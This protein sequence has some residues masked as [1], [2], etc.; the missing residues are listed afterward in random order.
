MSDAS[1]EQPANDTPP[2]PP[3][4][5]T[6]PQPHY[7]AQGGATQHPAAGQHPSGGQYPHAGQYP[8][9]GQYGAGG[10]QH[11]PGAYPQA[12]YGQG[13]YAYP[14]GPQGQYPQQ[15]AQPTYPSARPAD[16]RSAQGAAFG[17]A[18][19]DTQPTL[20]I[21]SEATE[22]DEPKK[23]SGAGKVI[24]LL[25]AAALVGGAAGI[26]GSFAYGA[27]V[28][29]TT[30]QAG[31]PVGGG[32]VVVNNTES[33]NSTTGVAAKVL[34]SVVTISVSSS[35]GGGSG[36]GVILTEDG[37]VVTNTHVVTLDG[38]SASSNI[39]V[40]T[41]DGR[42]YQAEIV[43]LDPLY[44]LAVIKLEG[45]SGLEPIT[46]GSSSDLNVG[47]VTIA[48]G[49]PLGLENT[50]TTGIVSALDRSIEIASSAVP[51]SGSDEGGDQGSGPNGPFQFDIPGFNQRTGGETI[52]IAV[53]QT[54]AAINPGN[55]GGALVNKDGELIGINVAIATA[56]GS[57]GQAG[58]IGVGFAIPSAVVERVVDEIID[59]GEA[60]HGLLG[61]SVRSAGSMEGATIAGAY[62]A[63]VVA[64]GAA[65]AAGLKEGDI[66]TAF[67]GT[68]VSDST[69]LTAF[70]RAA[71]AGSDATVTYVR[72]GKTMTADV[73]L[74]S[75]E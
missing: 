70:V 60:T 72:D 59:T 61:A 21:T 32:T 68:S 38:A 50:V 46:F 57:S 64:D 5:P 7:G 24:G 43:G 8:S 10:Q 47:D 23:K 75:L 44:D 2:V 55:S 66:V 39:S 37:Y 30:V 29:T 51:D 22:S 17:S 14:R 56:G 48:F 34:P 18:A 62:I 49:A 73:T 20:P 63:E 35:S 65:E 12:P 54:D 42:I 40:T 13:P 4:P 53:L 33:V 36:S 26:G 15:G 45:A 16:S 69:D 71:A 9:A 27:L 67:N 6:P 11:A 31:A 52:K 41:S 19:S 74:G 28:P 3:V 25:V 1:N 58:S